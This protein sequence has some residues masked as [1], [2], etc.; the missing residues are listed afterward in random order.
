MGRTADTYKETRE[1][2]YDDMIVRVHIPDITEAER[3]RRMKQVQKAACEL[4]K[5]KMQVRL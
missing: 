1:F 5:N 2:I 3:T 4:L